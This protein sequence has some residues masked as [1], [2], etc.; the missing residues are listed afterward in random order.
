[1]SN[2]DK[3]DSGGA[4]EYEDVEELLGGLGFDDNTQLWPHE[5]HKPFGNF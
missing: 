3:I 2:D 5:P 1:M 4:Q